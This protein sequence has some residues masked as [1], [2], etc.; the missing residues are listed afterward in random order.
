MVAACINAQGNFDADEDKS[1][2]QFNPIQPAL[3]G[4]PGLGIN[5]L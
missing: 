1:Y 5:R 2:K 3:F 4:V